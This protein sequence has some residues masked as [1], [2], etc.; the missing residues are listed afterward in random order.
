AGALDRTR[1][2]SS[3]RSGARLLHA[4]ALG[5][6]ADNLIEIDR[7][8]RR[9]E[10]RSGGNGMPMVDTLTLPATPVAVLPMRLSHHA[11]DSLVILQE[12]G[13]S[14]L[15]V[16]QVTIQSTFTVTNTSDSGPGSLRAAILSAN[17]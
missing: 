12:G 4:H 16:S 13:S 7:A 5:G 17:G 15:S 2:V 1:L 6:T 9:I 3:G 8:G 10:V 11:L 14:P